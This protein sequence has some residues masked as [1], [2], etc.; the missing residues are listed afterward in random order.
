M[1]VVQVF[2]VGV[3]VHGAVSIPHHGHHSIPA[4]LQIQIVPLRSH[5]RISELLLG[6]ADLRSAK[7]SSIYGLRPFRGR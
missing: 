1:C 2:T 6:G 5:P 4:S 7:I 3:V